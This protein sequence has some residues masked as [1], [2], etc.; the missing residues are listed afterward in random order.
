MCIFYVYILEFK[1]FYDLI[2]ESGE[3]VEELADIVP[4]GSAQ[5]GGGGDGR[6]DSSPPKKRVKTGRVNS[7]KKR[8]CLHTL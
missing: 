1:N 6:R 8:A 3:E 2:D 5:R 4:S 7:L